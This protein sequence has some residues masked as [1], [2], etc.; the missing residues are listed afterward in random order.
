[1]TTTFALEET[2]A[3]LKG[4]FTTCVTVKCYLCDTEPVD[5]LFFLGK[6]LLKLKWSLKMGYEV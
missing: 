6:S 2:K 5:F 1:M 4:D 3:Q